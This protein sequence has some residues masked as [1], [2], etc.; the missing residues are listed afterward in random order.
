MFSSFQPCG[1]WQWKK[2]PRYT[3]I[4]LGRKGERVRIS[5][6]T[7]PLK[8]AIQQVKHSVCWLSVLCRNY[9][10]EG[11]CCEC[12]YPDPCPTIYTLNM[13]SEFLCHDCWSSW[14]KDRA[15]SEATCLLESF[16]KC[17]LVEGFKNP[18]CDHISSEFSH[19]TENKARTRLSLNKMTKFWNVDEQRGAYDW[20]S[21]A[22]LK[23]N[24]R[25][26]FKMLSVKKW[27]KIKVIDCWSYPNVDL[28]RNI[29]YFI[30]SPNMSIKKCNKVKQELPP[31]WSQSCLRDGRSPGIT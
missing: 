25:R 2:S 18:Q 10:W 23:S 28:I 17:R 15:Y 29:F 1:S 9:L 13:L 26:V 3:L 31:L 19:D 22:Y 27:Q 21:N 14:G 8:Q 5:K 4:Y 6:Y 30:K 7:T 11:S 12:A 20:Q 24:W 16:W